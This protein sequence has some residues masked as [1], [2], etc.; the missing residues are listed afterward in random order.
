MLQ[1]ASSSVFLRSLWQLLHTYLASWRSLCEGRV[2][3]ILDICN[4]GM[5]LWERAWTLPCLPYVYLEV[6]LT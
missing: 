4:P 1:K 6:P 3:S 2:S 5:H